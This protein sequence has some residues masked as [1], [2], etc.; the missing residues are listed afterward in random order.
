[1]YHCELCERWFC[2]KHLKPRLFFIKDLDAIENIPEIRVLYYTEV[3]G[4]EG[5]PDFEYSRRKLVE[6]DIEEK[7]RNELIKQALDRMNHYYD[8]VS[9]PEKPID[10]EQERKRTFEML[11]KEEEE[12]E[13]EQQLEKR[14]KES[15]K[16]KIKIVDE[17]D[18]H[19]NK[20]ETTVPEEVYKN[21]EYRKKI[22]R[23]K[24]REEVEKIVLEY[25]ESEVQ[26]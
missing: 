23:A 1:V 10:L 5:H 7:R 20:I 6:L 16:V 13:K 3:K 8:E 9:I 14:K 19:Y 15:K 2:E 22:E 21:K 12:I 17:G 11:L 18:Y 4:K 24:T 25:Y 26:K